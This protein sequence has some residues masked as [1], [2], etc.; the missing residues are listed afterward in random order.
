MIYSPVPIFAAANLK[1]ENAAGARAKV[2]SAAASAGP[3][4]TSFRALVLAAWSSGELD[5]LFAPFKPPAKGTLAARARE[6]P[7][8]EA[9]VEEVLTSRTQAKATELS[10]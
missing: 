1:I 5:D 9:A 7:G 8:L 10:T 6:V 3:V 4:D 2:L